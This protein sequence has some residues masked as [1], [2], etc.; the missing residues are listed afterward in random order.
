MQR[1]FRSLCGRQLK[2]QKDV[3]CLLFPLFA[4]TILMIPAVC[5]LPPPSP[6]VSH[7]PSTLVPV[8]GDLALS[9]CICGTFSERRSL[10]GGIH[11]ACSM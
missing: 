3:F 5:C 8:T 9:T 6:H 4:L 2:N 1:P 7:C 11:T 10:F